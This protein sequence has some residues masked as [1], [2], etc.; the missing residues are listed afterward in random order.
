MKKILLFMAGS[1]VA[2]LIFCGVMYVAINSTFWLSDAFSKE[3]V[4]ITETGLAFPDRNGTPI[5]HARGTL[6]GR[7]VFVRGWYEVGQE[8]EVP[9]RLISD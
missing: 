4:T 9:S 3:K 6:N 8:V 7:E 1:C 2:V 5:K